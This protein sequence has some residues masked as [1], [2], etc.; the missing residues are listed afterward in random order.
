[1]GNYINSDSKGNSIGTTFTEK[2][3]NLIEDGALKIDT[4]DCFEKD[5]VCLVDN[6][7]FAAAAH[8]YDEREM[9]A[10]KKGM[11]GRK[12]QWF[13]FDKAEQLAQ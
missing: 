3:E 5:L 2:Q 9:N 13:K 1:M 10:F 6:G 8:V 7:M 4:P 12:Y 11:G